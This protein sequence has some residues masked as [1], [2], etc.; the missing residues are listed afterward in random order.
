[1]QSL[2]LSDSRVSFCGAGMSKGMGDE[3]GCVDSQL[4]SLN[5]VLGYRDKVVTTPTTRDSIS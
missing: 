4:F 5:G 1:M 3:D 2:H